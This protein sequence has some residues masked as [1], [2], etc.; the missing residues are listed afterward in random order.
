[1]T[2]LPHKTYNEQ[3]NINAK[4]QNLSEEDQILQS[5]KGF[6]KNSSS[7]V[8]SKCKKTKQTLDQKQPSINDCSKKMLKCTDE[9]SYNEAKEDLDVI[10]KE[11]QTFIPSDEQSPLQDPRITVCELDGKVM[12]DSCQNTLDADGDVATSNN[13]YN[14]YK[15]GKISENKNSI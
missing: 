1:M 8:E 4:I 7:S 14:N 12:Y 9:N 6:K 2:T 15:T 11:L 5:K 10:V 3:R 13:T